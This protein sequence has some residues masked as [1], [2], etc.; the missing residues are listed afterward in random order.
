MQGTSKVGFSSYTLRETNNL[1][2]CGSNQVIF[3]SNS[4]QSLG[5]QIWNG[6]SNDVK[7]AENLK[8]FKN[9]LKNERVYCKYSLCRNVY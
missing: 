5:L 4:R 8:I 3:V 2:H 6:L 7:S 1:Q 9:I